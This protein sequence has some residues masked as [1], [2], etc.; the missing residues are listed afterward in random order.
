MLVPVLIFF[1]CFVAGVMSAARWLP[2]LAPGPI[3][4]L[5]FFTVVI[6]ELTRV[7]RALGGGAHLAATRSA[8]S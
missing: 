5:A 6:N 8:M 4:G 3:G 7:A 2:D 1:V